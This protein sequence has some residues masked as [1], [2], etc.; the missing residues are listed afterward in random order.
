MCRR[1]RSSCREHDMPPRAASSMKPGSARPSLGSGSFGPFGGGSFLM[2]SE[3]PLDPPGCSAAYATTVSQPFGMLLKRGNSLCSVASTAGR[4]SL[5]QSRLSTMPGH[6]VAVRA[7][8][9]PRFVF[10]L[11]G[12]PPTSPSGLEC[13]RSL[14]RGQRRLAERTTMCSLLLADSTP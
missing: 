14:R 7:C 4:S 5:P 1:H 13:H 6:A 10:D 9:P 2:S 12:R 11:G 3:L 8:F